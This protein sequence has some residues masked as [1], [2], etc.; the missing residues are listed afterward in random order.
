MSE[1]IQA[2]RDGGSVAKTARLEH[3]KLSGERVSTK[4]NYEEISESK[5][6]KGI[7]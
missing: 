2:A 4:T 6:R 5:Q 3:E 7:Q 1:N